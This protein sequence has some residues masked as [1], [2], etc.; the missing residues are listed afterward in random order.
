MSKKMTSR[1]QRTT[2]GRVVDSQTFQMSRHPAFVEAVNRAANLKL[3]EA[4]KSGKLRPVLASNTTGPLRY[5]PR[6]DL[7]DDPSSSKFTAIFELPGIQTSQISLQIR[8]GQLV[9]AGERKAPPSMNTSRNALTAQA[10]ASNE[11]DTDENQTSRNIQ[12]P[13]QEL[14]YGSFFRSLRIPAGIQ[15]SDVKATLQDGM[16]TVTWPRSPGVSTELAHNLSSSTES[17][18]GARM[19]TSPRMPLGATAGTALQ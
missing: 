17:A 15:E 9:I 11:M 1:S 6:M 4:I 16:L 13:I 19:P 8:E 10:V 18:D 3:A 7:V 14:R 5:A 12:Y 2:N